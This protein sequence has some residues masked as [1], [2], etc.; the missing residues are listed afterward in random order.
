MD[1]KKRILFVDDDRSVLD[2][3]RRMLHK[4][5]DEWRMEFVTRA[6][7][8]MKVMKNTHYDIV[9]S[10]LRMPAKDGVEAGTLCQGGSTGQG[11]LQN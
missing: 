9:V 1:E 10:D 8:A 4:M 7:D 5:R 3:L 11:D 2:G 6:S